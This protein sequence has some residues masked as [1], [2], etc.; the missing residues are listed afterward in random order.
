MYTLR[1]WFWVSKANR[2][3]TFSVDR[4][5]SILVVDT[6]IDGW[7]ENSARLWPK[8][9]EQREHFLLPE[10]T[11]LQTPSISSSDDSGIDTVF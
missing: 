6:K 8:H 7:Y 3:L 1:W 11:P 2:T 4:K 5:H 10:L 9:T